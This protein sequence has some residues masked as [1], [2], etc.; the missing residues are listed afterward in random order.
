MPDETPAK[1]M[2]L[3]YIKGRYSEKIEAI[4]LVDNATVADSLTALIER[5]GAKAEVID[6]PIWPNM[7]KQGE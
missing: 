1:T 3:I 6:V 7:R 5:T 4:T 2:T